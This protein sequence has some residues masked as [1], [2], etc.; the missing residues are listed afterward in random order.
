MFKA[1]KVLKI[2]ESAA[3]VPL[4]VIIDRNPDAVV[5]ALG[6]GGDSGR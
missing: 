1:G 4:T 2:P 5:E 3:R 6:E